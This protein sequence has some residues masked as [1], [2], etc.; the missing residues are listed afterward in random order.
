MKLVVS[1]RLHTIPPLTLHYSLRLIR[2]PMGDIRDLCL[3]SP[4]SICMSIVAPLLSLVGGQR[5]ERFF[6]KEEGLSVV[7]AAPALAE[8]A[9]LQPHTIS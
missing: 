6:L 9:R 4:R 8:F 5:R 3:V 7:V 1:S 2:L